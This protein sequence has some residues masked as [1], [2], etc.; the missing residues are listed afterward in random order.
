MFSRGYR[1]A[2]P[3]CNGLMQDIIDQICFILLDLEGL[4][5]SSHVEHLQ[6][7]AQVMLH[8]YSL[9]QGPRV[10]FGQILLKLPLLSEVPEAV[11]EKHF[12]KGKLDSI[13]V[14]PIDQLNNN[15]S[16]S[17]NKNINNN[18]NNNIDKYK[19]FDAREDREIVTV[20]PVE[21]K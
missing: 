18:D 4:K 19:T 2:T 10:R 11:V 5:S 14:V 1:K 7:K 17:S 9:S 13:N 21:I 6:E 20:Y 15:N 8:D 3:G 16:N 12:F